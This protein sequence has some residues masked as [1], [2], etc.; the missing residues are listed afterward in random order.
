MPLCIVNVLADY[1]KLFVTVKCNNHFSLISCSVRSCVRQGRV[2]SPV[3]RNHFIVCIRSC[4]L[5]CYVNR[6]LVSCILYTDDIFIS[7]AVSATKML[8]VL[9]QISKELLLEFDASKSFCAL[10]GTSP[11]SPH[12]CAYGSYLLEGSSSVK[13][14]CVSFTALYKRLYSYLNSNNKLYQYQFGF[15]LFRV[16]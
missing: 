16:K 9:H 1:G 13:Y 12:S 14:L 11:T 8:H 4:D 2:L 15:P 5:G 7:L 3:F 6:A 10:F